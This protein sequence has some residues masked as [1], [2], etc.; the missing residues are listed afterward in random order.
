M[1]RVV[2]D[3]TNDIPRTYIVAQTG[4]H[5]LYRVLTAL[6]YV[7]PNIGYCQGLNLVAGVLHFVMQSEERAF[8]VLLGMIHK[9]HMDTLFE[10]GVPDLPLRE[11][12]M[13]HFM[14]TYLPSLHQHCR[15]AEISSQLFLSKWIMTVYA[16][17]LPLN[18]LL[19]VWDCFIVQGWQA[20]FKVGIA[21]LK[22]L[23]PE[24]MEADLDKVSAFFRASQRN[25]HFEG[26][27][28][29]GEAAKV[30]ITSLEVGKAE[31]AYFIEQARVKLGHYS[32]T[33]GVALRVAKD[34]LHKLDEPSRKYVAAFQEKIE[35]V[36]KE[37]DAFNP[38]YQGTC[39]DLQGLEL[40][41]DQ[42]S[43]LKCSYMLS[44]KSTK[45]TRKQ[46]ETVYK[47]LLP[48]KSHTRLP[49]VTVQVQQ[50]QPSA[51]K[52]FFREEDISLTRHKLAGIDEE[53]RGL[54]RQHT[55]KYAVYCEARTQFDGMKERKA[56]YISQLSGFL[57][58][59]Q[60][61]Q[62]ETLVKLSSEFKPRRT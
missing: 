43:E 41:I 33:D 60:V 20:V 28:L 47:Q 40:N 23:T 36:S 18:T 49:V 1:E 62:T 13:Q 14:K 54:Q 57:E 2:I 26:R 32:E 7:K 53:L 19:H 56:K 3:I 48:S 30:P 37:L 6:A 50:P 31:E 38:Y 16:S 51:S 8:W 11:H 35:R 34:Q 45:P 46:S 4:Q 44:L 55:E 21:I 27:Q 61:K 9:Q 59:L 10:Q 15:S 24:L 5:E 42:L 52:P 12:Q 22:E 17:Y 58:M 25:R 29:L 39:M